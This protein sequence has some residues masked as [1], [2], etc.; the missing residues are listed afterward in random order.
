MS[1]TTWY[2]YAPDQKFGVRLAADAERVDRLLDQLVLRHG[3]L[4]GGP[5]TTAMA[6]DAAPEIGQ[7]GD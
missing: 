1:V 6:L 2:P 7:T 3:D 5:V 4:L